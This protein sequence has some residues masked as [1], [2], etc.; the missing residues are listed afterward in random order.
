MD[1]KNYEINIEQIK[2]DFKFK[3]NG[4]LTNTQ[5][6]KYFLFPFVANEKNLFT[7]FLG[8]T[9]E[10]SRMICD[11]RL[12]EEFNVE[13]FIEKM[14]D[15]IDEYEGEDSKETLKDIINSMFINEGKLENF[16]IK[17]INY[18]SSTSSDKKV[19]EYIYCN[20][21]SE[22][23][24]DIVKENYN[25]QEENLLYKLVSESLPELQENKSVSL[26]GIN[27]INF[28]REL[29][30]KDFK[31]LISNEELYKNSLKRFLEYYYIFYTSQIILKLSKFED[32][33]LQNPEPLYYTLN[34]ESVSKNRTSYRFGWELLKSKSN[35]IF[36]HAITLEM[37]NY[38]YLDK[39]L[40]YND[41]FE[42][43]KENDSKENNIKEQ[44]NELINVYKEKLGIN[45]EELKYSNKDSGN[46]IFNLVYKLFETVEYQFNKGRGRARANQ[47]YSKW[48]IKFVEANFGKR[49]GALGYTLNLDE[50]DIILITKL[51]I[52]NNEKLKL[53]TLFEEFKK[54]GICFDRNSSNKIVQLY[55]KLNL[56][57]KK[58][59][60]GDAQYVRAI[61]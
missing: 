11:K 19:A 16:N 28:V 7:D 57:E 22:N 52:N 34:W 9:G 26:K 24:K 42:I 4:G 2:F 5:G 47:A 27:Y 56:L 38:H 55:E 58:S 43:F 53:N 30:I 14:L 36:A 39:K 17:T 48:F 12:L 61:L 60:S 1:E 25:K 33:D 10:F 50:E 18:I 15:K 31:F 21:F 37:L 35:S 51:C 54:R 13:K 20:L 3:E 23:L 29:F 49:R 6:N 45:E 32:A 40:S 8:V 59:D 46:E 44:I 41:L